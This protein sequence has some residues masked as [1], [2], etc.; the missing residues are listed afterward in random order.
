[1]TTSTS[2]P[3]LKTLAE[4][5]R[6]ALSGQ[7]GPTRPS[8]R[9]PKKRGLLW[10]VFLLMIAG[11]TGYAVWRAHQPAAPQTRQGGRAGRD[12]TGPVP[13]VVTKVVRS[14]IPV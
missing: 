9:N 7:H 8:S 10:L 4:V 6:M 2:P 13:V 12:A 14:S 1:M 3:E 5:D 11:V